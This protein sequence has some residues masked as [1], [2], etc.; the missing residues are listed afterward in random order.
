MDHL[1]FITFFIT[2]E[3]FSLCIFIFGTSQ[4]GGGGGGEGVIKISTTYWAE[5]TGLHAH[6]H[7]RTFNMYQIPQSIND[8]QPPDQIYS[9]GELASEWTN[10]YPTV[11]NLSGYFSWIFPLQI[12]AITLSHTQTPIN[13]NLSRRPI[14]SIMK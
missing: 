7:T 1:L 2:H 4:G 13:F 14:E 5:L 12:W 10:P 9:G 8:Y 6:T 11:P 3:V